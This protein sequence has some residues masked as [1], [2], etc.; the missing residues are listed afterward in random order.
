MM[1]GEKRKKLTKRIILLILLSTSVASVIVGQKMGYLAVHPYVIKGI[2]V[3]LVGIVSLLSVNIILRLTEHR[4]FNM[5]K[6]EIELEQRIFIANIYKGLLYTTGLSFLL[7]EF[8]LSIQN[9]TIFL[10]LIATGFAFAVRDF[11]MSYLVWIILLLKKPVRIGDCIAIDDTKGLITRIGNFFITL[12]VSETSATV[13]VP[14]KI[15]LNNHIQNFG[16]KR[17][18]ETVTV[19]LLNYPHEIDSVFFKAREIMN[20]VNVSE[21]NIRITEDTGRYYL[22]VEY[23][24][25]F[26]EKQSVYEKFYISLLHELNRDEVF[27]EDQV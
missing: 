19:P 21:E 22:A 26:Y 5:M 1:I 14:N 13:K 4:V 3:V 10:G 20:Q 23:Y 12:D 24:T 6:D 2:R 11:I 7:V 27:V 17:I 8:G 25:D 15:I 16:Q 18:L 9:I